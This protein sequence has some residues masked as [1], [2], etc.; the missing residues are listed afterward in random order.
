MNLFCVRSLLIGTTCFS[1]SLPAQSMT[2]LQRFSELT[3]AFWQWNE[4]TDAFNAGSTVNCALHQRGRVWFLAGAFRAFRAAGVEEGSGFVVDSAV[5]ECT[6]PIPRGKQLF[7]PL[8][9]AEVSKNDCSAVPPALPCSNEDK[10]SYLND[11]FEG[12]GEALFFR[13]EDDATP[14]VRTYSCQLQAS[15]NGIPLQNLKVPIVRVQSA[16]FPLPDDP[17]AVSDGYYALLPVL[18]SGDHEIAFSGALCDIE[19]APTAVP[20]SVRFKSEVTYHLTIR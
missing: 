13:D 6:A 11:L 15:I 4:A 2:N 1:L 5:R 20:E 14:E 7:F 17:G 16:A 19:S 9:N 12:T 8:V 3:A 10:R 18:A